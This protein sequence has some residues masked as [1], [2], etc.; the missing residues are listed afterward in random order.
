[1]LIFGIKKAQTNRYFWFSI[2]ILGLFLVS[3]ILHH[4]IVSQIE[5][6]HEERQTSFLLAD[7][8]LQTSDT[9][10]LM[11][12]KYIKTKT[13]IYKIQYLKIIDVRNGKAPLPSQ[14]YNN[15]WN[16]SMEDNKQ[17]RDF[18]TSASSLVDRINQ[19]NITPA[20][21]AQLQRA[22]KASEALTRTDRK[23]M[24]LFESSQTKD[25]AQK[26]LSMLHSDSYY[27]TKA[28]IRI[29]LAKFHKLLQQRSGETIAS[30]AS[31]ATYVRAVLISTVFLLT[32]VLWR[33]LVLINRTNGEQVEKERMF[34]AVFENAAV[35]LVHVDRSGLILQANQSFCNTLGYT[36]QDVVAPTFNFAQIFY[37]QTVKS[38]LFGPTIPQFENNNQCVITEPCHG[39]NDRLVW[40]RFFIELLC[41]DTEPLQ[42]FIVAAVDVTA[43]KESA[44]Q[45]AEYRENL[46]KVVDA[47]TVKLKESENRFRFIAENTHDVI[48]TMDLKN[49][50][51]SYVSP[52][53]Y[54]QRG[55]TPAEALKGGLWKS[56][57]PD[58]QKRIRTILD[59]LSQTWESGTP[60]EVVRVAE[61]DQPHKDGHII[62]TEVI[63]SLLPK[64]EN[65]HGSLLGVTRDIT[66]RKKAEED[67]LK[68]AF[69]DG[70]TQ[71]PNRRLLLDRLHHSIA[72][73]G[74][75][76]TRVA[77]LF[78]DLDNF[79][80]IND[81]QGH[82]MG[83]W[84]LQAVAQRMITC[85]R[86]Y[87]TAARIGGDEFI[88][89]LPDIQ[90]ISD[91]P[92]IAER[93]RMSLGKPFITENET[94]LNITT[95]IG[96]A[97][98]P[99]H[100]SNERDLLRVGDEAM[101]RAKKTGRNKVE[102]ISF[103]N[104]PFRVGDRSVEDGSL[105][106]TWKPTFECGEPSIDSEHQ[107][108][109]RQANRVVSAAMMLPENQPELIEELDDL[110]FNIEGHF[111]HE[112]S[113]LSKQ[114]YPNL[115]AHI[116]KHQLLLDKASRLKN[117]AVTHKVSI[118]ELID[119]LVVEVI[120][121]HVLSDDQEYYQHATDDEAMA[122]VP[123]NPT[124]PPQDEFL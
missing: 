86:S 113:I 107:E 17:S 5:A 121:Q 102:M 36:H 82:H 59:E 110:L 34:K 90:Q 22:Q 29:P 52:S 95:S 83:D 32:F 112:E 118:R 45:L 73:A 114:K 62:H 48:W 63:I 14:R 91:A 116:N 2:A 65:P 20:Q 54:R 94:E 103:P 124:L 49:K 104:F 53:V 68:L 111:D 33:L 67:I 88:V 66:A 85:L 37:S 117:L 27:Q 13:P 57:L 79:K 122:L 40:T 56:L 96:I 70:L 35:G 47:R 1:M 42:S 15:Y 43:E 11:A 108:L 93:I 105:R 30:A 3:F 97:L 76:E 64:S 87:D 25:T 99:D 101:Y 51:F 109:F 41:R 106:L 6:V 89:L 23:A 10:T 119:F 92:T 115:E 8:L 26:A 80:P 50:K 9:L 28:A 78:I 98:F 12:R 44:A 69:Y 58:S 72:Q 4:L 24:T 31:K 75:K 71:L 39:K 7:E 84:L 18:T 38:K 46:E 19:A 55:F 81:D 60:S 61:T 16:I 21:R 77:L 123:P 120:A 100:A 74:R